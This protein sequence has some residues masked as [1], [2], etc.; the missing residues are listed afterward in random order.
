[1]A[2]ARL[3]GVFDEGGPVAVSVFPG[4]L[5]LANLLIAVA[6]DLFDSALCRVPAP[7]GINADAWWKIIRRAARKRPYL[8]RNHR[9][10]IDEGYLTPGVSAAVSF[11]TGGGKSTLA[12][13]K[14][15]AALL[16]EKKVVVLAPA[17]ALVEQTAF[18]LG[19]A[20]KDYEVLSDLDE[21]VS[22][23]EVVEL[24]EII[25]TT[26]ESR[27]GRCREPTP[28]TP[29]Y[30]PFPTYKAA[31]VSDASRYGR[32]VANVCAVSTSPAHWP[33]TRRRGTGA[34][35]HNPEFGSPWLC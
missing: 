4:P 25:V 31:G 29:H 18:A 14:I 12:E 24:P 7:P 21:E 2:L 19:N 26:P 30:A 6:G 15:A 11:P 22:F 23:T 17:L 33:A 35:Q 9:E 20:F 10:A 5:H 13:L 3:E 32:G 27:R 28:V 16:A 8:W 1:M 34:G